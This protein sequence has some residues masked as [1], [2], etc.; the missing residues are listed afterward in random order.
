MLVNCYYVGFGNIYNVEFCSKTETLYKSGI[1]VK[2]IDAETIQNYT[3]ENASF[4]ML[5]HHVQAFLRKNTN[6]HKMIIYTAMDSS[7]INEA[8]KHPKTA[9]EVY[10]SELYANKQIDFDTRGDAHMARSARFVAQKYIELKK[11]GQETKFGTVSNN[12][13]DDIFADRYNVYN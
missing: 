13:F 11:A 1:T 12:P 2:N 8:M 7:V 4:Y 9:A 3:F 6:V 5:M 10:F